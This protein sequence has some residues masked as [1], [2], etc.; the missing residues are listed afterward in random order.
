[1]TKNLTRGFLIILLVLTILFIGFKENYDSSQAEDG[2]KIVE[3]TQTLGSV[4]N[5]NDT[6]IQTYNYDF[7]LYN[8]GN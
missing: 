5:V 1:M 4:E 6:S 3:T 2:L 7:A 8:G